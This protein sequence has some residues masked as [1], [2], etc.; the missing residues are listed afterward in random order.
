MAESGNTRRFLHSLLWSE[1]ARN[2]AD[3]DA[4][5]PRLQ[6]GHKMLT[7]TIALDFSRENICLLLGERI[8]IW[9]F[10]LC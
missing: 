3:M 6:T 5:L 10:A 8:K 9:E 4:Q 1:Q 7:Q 2:R